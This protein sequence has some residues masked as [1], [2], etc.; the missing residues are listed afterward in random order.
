MT[1]FRRAWHRLG[2]TSSASA[3][4]IHDD[5]KARELGF[6][7]AF[8]PGSVVASAAIPL[9]FER[10]GAQ[11][12]DGGWFSFAFAAPV[13]SSEEVMAYAADA[14]DGFE[15]SVVTR[16]Q[17]LCC[18]GQA[19]AGFVQPWRTE[20]TPDREVFPEL[21]IGFA[22]PDANVTISREDVGPMLQAAHDDTSWYRGESPWGEALAPP[23]QL[24]P[25]A[26]Q[27]MRGT[28]LALPGIKGPGIWARHHL[29]ISAPLHYDE[30]YQ[31][32]QWVVDK[33]RS[34]RTLF[35][36]Y[37]F[38]LTRGG[39]VIVLGAHRGKWLAA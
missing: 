25:I 31:F 28:R 8:V 6:R 26:L 11:W 36:E 17:R 13:Y 22:F 18:A 15:L 5:D 30:G 34:G 12:I 29:S 19:G 32:S 23:E 10:F 20:R 21:E 14:T 1:E 39:D 2:N 35:V 33:G 24:F 27:T 16:G 38:S 9:I 3:G 4:T 7:G 37:E